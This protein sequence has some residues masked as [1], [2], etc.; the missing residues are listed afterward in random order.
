[1]IELL[2]RLSDNNISVSLSGDDLELTFDDETPN[3]DLLQ[4]IR[5]NKQEIISFLKNISLLLVIRK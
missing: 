3:P 4:K 5:D 2:E 1:M